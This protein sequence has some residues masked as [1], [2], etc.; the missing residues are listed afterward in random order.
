MS[1]YSV[2]ACKQQRSS[3]FWWVEILADC[4][5]HNELQSWLAGGLFAFA[6]DQR[7]F[8]VVK[9]HLSY[10]S[11]SFCSRHIPEALLKRD[12]VLVV[13]QQSIGW[14]WQ[15]MGDACIKLGTP[16]SSCGRLYQAVDACIKLWI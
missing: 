9:S 11:A 8:K 4:A 6:K 15:R 13:F 1:S 7:G 10:L 16:V 2:L 14:R 3:P 12:P 5:E